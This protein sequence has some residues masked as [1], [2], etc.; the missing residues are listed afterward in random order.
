MALALLIINFYQVV[1]QNGMRDMF[2]RGDMDIDEDELGEK[3][4]GE[5]ESEDEEDE[6][7]EVTPLGG[8]EDV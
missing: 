7:G 3:P 5:E 8:E 2:M 4:V 6:V 1:T